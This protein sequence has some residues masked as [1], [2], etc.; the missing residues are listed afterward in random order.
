VVELQATCSG[1]CDLSDCWPASDPATPEANNTAPSE[2]DPAAEAPA[3]AEEQVLAAE[4]VAGV[5]ES[6]AAPPPADT[7]IPMALPAAELLCP[8]CQAHVDSTMRFCDSCGWPLVPHCPDC[9]TDNRS[10]AKFCRSC[11]A[12]LIAKPERRGRTRFCPTCGHELTARTTERR[13]ETAPVPAAQP[14]LPRVETPVPV[15]VAEEEP[16]TSAEPEAPAASEAAAVEPVAEGLPAREFELLI[17]KADGTPLAAFPLTKGH[18]LVGV[19]VPGAPHAPA[20]DLSPFDNRKVI[21]RRHALF[22]VSGNQILLADC[23][24]T[25]GTTVD[26]QALTKTPVEVTEES[27]IAFAGLRCRIRAK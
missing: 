3:I 17:V 12:R 9:G 14:Q 27:A 16:A 15:A 24:S 6:E 19:R 10:G 13:T 1:G 25:N 23:G 8:G 18:N 2:P 5:A 22:Q 21:S 26:D 4:A 11:G 7:E 20:V